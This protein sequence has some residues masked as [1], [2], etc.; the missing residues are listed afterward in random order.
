MF[1]DVHTFQISSSLELF[2]YKLQKHAITCCDSSIMTGQ[3]KF[4]QAHFKATFDQRHE[5]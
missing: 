3:K 4:K 2:T 1:A 5:S